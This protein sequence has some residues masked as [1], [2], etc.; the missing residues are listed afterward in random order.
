MGDDSRP[1]LTPWDT[2]RPFKK[3]KQLAS[4]YVGTM[5]G[6]DLLA[7]TSGVQNRPAKKSSIVEGEKYFK[8]WKEANLGPNTT[9]RLHS[10]MIIL[11]TFDLTT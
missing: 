11:N 8:A 3:K 1:R 4:Y 9:L 6:S 2:Q 10:Q 7:A 5:L